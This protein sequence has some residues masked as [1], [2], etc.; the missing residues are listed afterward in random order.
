MVRND[1][2]GI[3]GYI[4]A[5]PKLILDAPDWGRKV[6]ETTLARTRPSE[7]EDNYILQFDGNAAGSEEMLERITEG[8]P[9]LI[10]GE[11]RSENEHDPKPEENRV[12]IYI[13]AEV[14]AINDLP[15]NDQNEVKIYGNICKL[16]KVRTTRRRTAKGKKV[17][18]ANVIVAVNTKTGTYY[19][20]CVCWN[21]AAYRAGVLKVG[22][23]VEIYG[24]FQSRTFKKRI[25]GRKLPF[26]CTAYEVS[27][28][29]LK[30]ESGEKEQGKDN[31]NEEL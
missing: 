7:K 14:I 8:A 13:Y 24:R 22:D 26:L 11:I 25:E 29:D 16:P 3:T 5:P 20:P 9:V 10:G 17:T 27:V 12:K 21:W 31:E 23:Y 4:T 1:T 28:I 18:T 30:S 6:Y 2:I 19:I 15:V